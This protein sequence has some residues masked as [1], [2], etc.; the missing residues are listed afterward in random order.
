MPGPFDPFTPG[1]TVD[2]TQV[3]PGPQDFGIMN[4]IGTFLG[5][6]RIQGGLLS[7]GLTL[8]QP[9]GFAQDS[10]GQ[11]AQALGA[12][13]ASIRTGEAGELK[14]REG[15]AKAA[16][17]EARA[18]AA[19]AN[20]EARGARADTASERLRLQAEEMD[21]RQERATQQTQLRALQAYE[22][23]KKQIEKQNDPLTTKPADRKP[24]P[25]F[26]EW[27]KS[28]GLYGAP[29][30]KGMDLNTGIPSGAGPTGTR[31]S[32]E[33]DPLGLGP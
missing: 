16:L 33:D 2:P 1:P 7:A 10:A 11:L 21:R 30:T 28:R 27:L 29:W 5:D 20:A 17:A 4:Q 23:H 13:G 26:G 6:P 12:A 19:G 8:M 3:L 14:Q 25:T 24:V 9:R 15:E 31:P 22:A 32:L 18:G